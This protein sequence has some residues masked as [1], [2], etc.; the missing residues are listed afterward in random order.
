MAYQAIK[1]AYEWLIISCYRRTRRST[2]PKSSNSHAYVSFQVHPVASWPSLPIDP[3]LVPSIS[4]L[5]SLLSSASTS[6]VLPSTP[7]PSMVVTEGMPPLP[8]KLVERIRRWEFVDLSSLL[9][10]NATQ[11][12]ELTVNAVWQWILSDPSQK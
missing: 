8:I 9:K 1:L 5:P 11:P 7:A 10:E 6:D 3:L 12:A 2:L 4:S